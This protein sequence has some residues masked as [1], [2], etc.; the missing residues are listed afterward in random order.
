MAITTDA[1]IEFF[2]TEDDL[3]SSA[4][5]VADGAFSVVGD[6]TAWTNDDDAPMASVAL[7]F[8]YAT[9]P[10]A[11]SSI[12][13]FAALQNIES[14]NDQ[15]PPTANFLHTYLGAF[16]VDANTTIQ[17][18]AIDINLPNNYTSQLY[19]FFIQNNTGQT[20]QASWT[21]HVTP[22]TIGPHA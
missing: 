7:E 1:A 4:A 10:D 2:G 3:E 17:Y 19:H 6:L 20:I 16:P 9:N 18:V 14:T 13:L 8:D 5:T 21:M 22:K 12:S 15:I 11:N